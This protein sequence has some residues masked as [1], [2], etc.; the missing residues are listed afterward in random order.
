M[1]SIYTQFPRSFCNVEGSNV[2]P[3]TLNTLLE[4]H[5]RKGISKG[6]S[7]EVWCSH[8]HRGGEMR[9]K[10]HHHFRWYW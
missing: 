4:V 1:H 6:I 2:S 8:L 3:T 7:Y 9:T 5:N 10:M